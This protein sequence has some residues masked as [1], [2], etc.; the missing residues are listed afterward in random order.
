MV[1]WIDQDIPALESISR[2]WET[3][4]SRREVLSG[5]EWSDKY[6]RLDGLTSAEPGKYR[7]SR[8]PY[9]KEILDAFTDDSVDTI[10]VM[11]STQIGGTQFLMNCLGYV[12][13][14]DPEPALFVMPTED[15]LKKFADERLKPQFENN[16]VFS[17]RLRQK[18]RSLG[19]DAFKFI[20]MNLSF[21]WAGSPST[22]ASTPIRYLFMDELEKWPKFSGKEAN[23]RNLALERT[24]TY[25]SRRKVLQ[26]STPNL[27][28]G[29]I[30]RQFEASDKRRYWVPCPHCGTYDHLRF[31][32]ETVIW[33]EEVTV[34]QIEHGRL[35]RYVCQSCGTEIEDQLKQ[36][37]LL[38]GVWCPDGCKVNKKGK[39]V[40]E[41]PITSHRG[42]HLNALYSPWLTWS[43][44]ACEF[45]RS[46]DSPDTLMNFKNSWEGIPWVET[47][48]SIEEETIMRKALDYSA[49]TVPEG[50]KILT[51]GVDVQK[52]HGYI[53]IRG[54]G[55]NE[56]SWLIVAME[57]PLP[58]NQP[59]VGLKRI[60]FEQDYGLGADWPFVRMAAIDSGYRTSEV[61]N[62]CRQLPEL[63]RPIKGHDVLQ[64]APFYKNTVTKNHATGNVIPSGM[65]LMHI[66]RNFYM[67]KLSRLVNSQPGDLSQWHICHPIDPR[68]LRHMVSHRKVTKINHVTGARTHK[69]QEVGPGVQDHFLDCEVYATAAAD[70]LRLPEFLSQEQDEMKIQTKPTKKS[71]PRKRREAGGFLSGIGGRR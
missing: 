21:G 25:K 10:T 4:W 44:M 27:E 56:E 69:W 51:A 26:T 3:T 23:P 40:G 32:K 57:I 14:M 2:L 68:Y 64:G 42:Y 43:D 38:A 17:E 12:V 50:V 9:L 70:F 33:P 48:N 31:S 30:N 65:Q 60:L 47:I 36:Q 54:W 24:R 35:A 58:I 34:E 59:W 1:Q 39:I 7:V 6:Q 5:S 66:D 49:K 53:V 22:L 37:M 8:T 28:E 52:D 71:R 18:A 29:E 45:L 63:T 11:K 15:V 13:H 20:G 62:F 61:Y 16:P 55:A 46:K 67:D 41:I 19:K